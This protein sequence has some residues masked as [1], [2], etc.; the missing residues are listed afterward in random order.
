MT[1][2][3]RALRWVRKQEERVPLGAFNN[4]TQLFTKLRK[5]Y[6]P[7]AGTNQ[8]QSPLLQSNLV[9]EQNRK[10]S[11]MNQMKSAW[12]KNLRLVQDDVSQLE[13]MLKT[14]NSS[15]FQS[16][17]KTNLLSRNIAEKLD[18]IQAK[19]LK[20]KKD[21]DMLNQCLYA[22]KIRGQK[23]PSDD[24]PYCGPGKLFESVTEWRLA[25]RM[26]IALTSRLRENQQALNVI[27]MQDE[28][29]SQFVDRF[30][31]K[32][33]EDLA[34]AAATEATLSELEKII[35]EETIAALESETAEVQSIVKSVQKIVKMVQDMSIMITEQGTIVDRIDYNLEV[36]SVR[37]LKGKEAFKNVNG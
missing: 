17:E 34:A 19:F 7:A 18:Q 3:E 11:W 2:E 33:P 13:D 6:L 30:S 9:S 10:V 32:L 31:A 20:M 14:K 12:D 25:E 28:K 24:N 1:Y 37:T 29:A 4:H 8:T 27:I 26:C 35:N 36:A 21:V 22:K 5:R 23:G 16:D 15:F